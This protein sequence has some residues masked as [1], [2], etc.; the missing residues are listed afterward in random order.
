MVLKV[1]KQLTRGLMKMAGLKP[2]KVEIEPG[3]V[4]S[5][6]VPS[7]IITKPKKNKK[8]PEKPEKPVIVLVH[9]FAAEGTMT[10]QFQ[11]K[12]L[13]KKYA[14][15]IPD[16]LFFGDSITDKT[17][18]SVSI[19]AE[20][21]A[22]GLRKVG[23]EKC[24]VVGF[25]YGGMVGFKMAEI[26][27]DFV[28]AIVASGSIW[29][30]THSMSESILKELGFSSFSELLLP[31]SLKDLKALFSVGTHT[32][33]WFPDFLYKEF[34]EVMFP[35]KKEKDELLKAI[36]IDDKDMEI[37]NI[38]QRIHLM[39]GGSDEIFK[40]ELAQNMKEQLGNRTTLEVIKK[41][42]HLI[43]LERPC[44]FNRCLKKFLTSFLASNE[45]K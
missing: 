15:Y 39:W 33:Y 18:R 8:K 37:P 43:H 14:V 5:F 7:E 26:Y 19:Q 4:M 24:I 22:T 13:T 44:V 17:E 45:A 10:W 9:G 35:N 20:C 29:P 2:Y 38:S 40:P 21:L 30:L 25:S 11:V 32:K 36:V 42:G 34:L 31:G 6:W 1:Q 23:V 41:A 28:Q 16:L 27:P 3:T 12:A